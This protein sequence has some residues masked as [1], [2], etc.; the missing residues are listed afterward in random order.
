MAIRDLFESATRRL[1]PSGP[2][3]KQ[4]QHPRQH[5]RVSNPWHAVAIQPG[6]RHCRVVVA[7]L[8]E[9]YLSREAPRLP[10]AGCTASSCTCR[11]RHYDDRRHNGS[12]RDRQGRLLPNPGR[13]S[14][15]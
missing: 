13:R 5:I 10:L 15:D 4:P 3:A 9:R 14:T 1:R 6:S 7:R 2:A 8:G 11:Y 12:P